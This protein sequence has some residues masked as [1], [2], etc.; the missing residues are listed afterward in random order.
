MKEEKYCCLVCE[1]YESYD[2]LC[3]ECLDDQL[4]KEDEI[5]F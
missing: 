4:T 2:G 3:W 1:E 5:I